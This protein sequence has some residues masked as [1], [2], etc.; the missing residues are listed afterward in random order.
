[1]QVDGA[2]LDSEAVQPESQRLHHAGERRPALQRGPW[3]PGGPGARVQGQPPD[4]AGL[5]QPGPVRD[6]GR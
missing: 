2:D 3:L 6:P 4:P 1:M 5:R